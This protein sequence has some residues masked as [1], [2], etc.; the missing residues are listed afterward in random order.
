[1]HGYSTGLLSLVAPPLAFGG[2]VAINCLWVMPLALWQ[3]GR[4]RALGM[5][6]WLMVACFVAA[7]LQTAGYLW[8]RARRRRSLQPNTA[9]AAELPVPERVSPHERE[10]LP[11]P[12]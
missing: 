7:G 12:K 10:R 1:M 11:D 8:V 9:S 6:P 2:L 3:L 5:F 4:E